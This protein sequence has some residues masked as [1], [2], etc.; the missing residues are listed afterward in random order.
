M[1]QNNFIKRCF[2]AKGVTLIELMIG[3]VLSG[4][5]LMGLS[6]FYSSA[7]QFQKN[8][9]IISQA[10]QQMRLFLQAQKKHITLARN[11]YPAPGSILTQT[12]QNRN[13]SFLVAGIPT[14]INCGNP[15]LKFSTLIIE[16]FR[17]A[18]DPAT[19]FTERLRV[20]C[21]NPPADIVLDAPTRAAMTN[22]TPCG[23][24]RLPVIR[25]TRSDSLGSVYRMS[26]ARESAGSAA[27]SE[28]GVTVAT[29]LCITHN[30]PT[31][32]ANPNSFNLFSLRLR[33]LV[34]QGNLVK[35]REL[36]TTVPTPAQ[37]PGG[38]HVFSS[39]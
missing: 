25:I 23:G 36:T 13:C 3:V 11:P 1:Y 39:Q 24:L 9:S 2:E 7:I 18:E 34:R 19:Y 33:A 26:G 27:L 30:G 29:S 15:N 21:A 28:E 35:L 31:D 22:C 8:S 12:Y 37:G 38:V 32:P 4:V 10:D 16:R 17:N 14:M 20:E 5:T 6:R